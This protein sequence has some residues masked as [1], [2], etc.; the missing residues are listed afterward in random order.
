MDYDSH[1][2]AEMVKI[3][4]SVDPEVCPKPHLPHLM[5]LKEL[6]GRLLWSSAPSREYVMSITIQFA[7]S[8]GPNKSHGI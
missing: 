8:C 5:S 2:D 1:E 3:S 4:L 7:S 6:F